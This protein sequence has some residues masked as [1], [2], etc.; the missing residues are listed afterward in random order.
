MFLIVFNSANSEN[1]VNSDSD[2][3]RPTRFLKPSRSVET[4]ESDSPNK[5][6]TLSESGFSELTELAGFKTLKPKI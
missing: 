4:R 5:I 3:K 6:K 1:S 2:K